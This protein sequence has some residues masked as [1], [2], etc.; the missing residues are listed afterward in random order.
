LSIIPGDSGDQ[1]GVLEWCNAAGQP[2]MDTTAPGGFNGPSDML[3]VAG[4]CVAKHLYIN[5]ADEKRKR[6]EISIRIQTAA[7]HQVGKF[8]SRPIKVISKPSKKRQSV[9]NLERK[10]WVCGDD[11]DEWTFLL[12]HALLNISS[13]HSSWYNCL[14]I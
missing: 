6:V 4:R 12:M 5:D 11:V 3:P 10:L 9:K 2:V 8:D 1:T 14:T 7:N 13:L